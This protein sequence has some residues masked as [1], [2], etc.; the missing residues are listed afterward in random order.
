MNC[1]NKSEKCKLD[2]VRNIVSQV[3]TNHTQE[4]TS[5]VRRGTCLEY[6]LSLEMGTKRNQTDDFYKFDPEFKKPKVALRDCHCHSLTED[7]DNG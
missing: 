1:E 6:C 2:L 4:M 5:E 3:P 7:T